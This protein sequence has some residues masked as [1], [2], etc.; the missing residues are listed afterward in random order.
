MTLPVSIRDNPISSRG[1]ER[2]KLPHYSS[3]SDVRGD[4]HVSSSAEKREPE[5]NALSKRHNGG[6]FKPP[7]TDKKGRG[8]R[9]QMGAGV[10]MM[11]KGS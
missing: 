6:T 9:G 1:T 3:I 8:G 11:K 5:E 7:V 2:E 4:F 10:E